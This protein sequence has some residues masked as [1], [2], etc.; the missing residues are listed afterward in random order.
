MNSKN[1]F[2][3]DLDLKCVYL[4]PLKQNKVQMN[5]QTDTAICKIENTIHRLQLN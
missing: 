5:V 2:G 1:D 4:C 3:I